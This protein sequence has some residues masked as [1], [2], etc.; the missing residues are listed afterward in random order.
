[1]SRSL[2]PLQCLTGAAASCLFSSP[3]GG[4]D[5]DADMV[6]SRRTEPQ[7]APPHAEAKRSRG[8]WSLEGGRGRT[9]E[10]QVEREAGGRWVDLGNFRTAP[11]CAC[12]NNHGSTD[13]AAPF[14]GRDLLLLWRASCSCAWQRAC[15][16]C[17][18]LLVTFA[19]DSFSSAGTG[20]SRGI[21]I[22]LCWYVLMCFVFVR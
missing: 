11:P 12:L 17:V 14:P 7:R 4:D 6:S 15:G 20:M 16:G 13:L 3:A 2:T 21:W 19:S 8:S 10:A 9:E 22:C 18:F 1:M 5:A